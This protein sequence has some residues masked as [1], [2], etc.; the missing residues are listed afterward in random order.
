ME[1]KIG[2]KGRVALLLKNKGL[3]KRFINGKLRAKAILS[4]KHPSKEIW[5]VSKTGRVEMEE[6]L[7]KE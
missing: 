5:D 3:R 1:I 2:N 4:Q 6:A 7:G